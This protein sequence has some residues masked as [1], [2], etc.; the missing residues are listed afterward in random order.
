MPAQKTKIVATIGPASANEKTMDEMIKAGLDIIR[1]NFSHGDFAEHESKVKLARA[2]GQKHHQTI[3][4]MQDL[5]G[6]KFRLGDFERESVMLEAGKEI[7]LTPE[8]VVGT[9]EKVSINYPHLA[10]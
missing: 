7:I 10:R 8:A 6:P 9:P 2:L 3:A 4:V 1:L 5:S